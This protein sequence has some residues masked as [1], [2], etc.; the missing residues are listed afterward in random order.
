MQ[1]DRDRSAAAN[2]DE[3][4]SVDKR[5][6]TI[7][8]VEIVII[9]AAGVYQFYSLQNY[10]ISKQY[11]WDVQSHIN[12]YHFYCLDIIYNFMRREEAQESS[13]NLPKLNSK[14]HV[15][16]YESPFAIP[17]DAEVTHHS[18]RYLGWKKG[19]KNANARKRNAM[20]N[21]KYGKKE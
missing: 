6:I 15:P 5:L 12:K 16:N 9:V 11:I 20:K 4:T 19:K 13:T 14:G 21:L 8:I 7:S 1:K 3:T 17:D 18:Y 10:L 2:F